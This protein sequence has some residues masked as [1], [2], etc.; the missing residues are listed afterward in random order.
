[1][2]R[3]DLAPGDNLLFCATGVTDGQLLRGVR[4]FGGGYRTQTLFMSLG[5]KIIRFVD[6]IHR[7]DPGTPVLFR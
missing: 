7:D 6:T 1:M 4:F 3:E 5:R 2:N